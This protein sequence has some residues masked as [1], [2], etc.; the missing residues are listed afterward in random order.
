LTADFCVLLLTDRPDP[1]PGRALGPRGGC[2]K[3]PLVA[4]DI[5]ASPAAISQRLFELLACIPLR[6]NPMADQPIRFGDG[7]AYE[8]MMG[9]WSR[10]AGEV[11]LDLRRMG[12]RHQG[13]LAGA[14]KHTFWH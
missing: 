1:P 6:D 8:R 12:Q 2:D 10:L 3:T 9:V 14:L 4:A 13:P 11:F 5:R 7:A